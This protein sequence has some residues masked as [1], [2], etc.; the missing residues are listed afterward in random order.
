MN[1]KPHNLS[2]G[3]KSNKQNSRI[4][5]PNSSIFEKESNKEEEEEDEKTQHVHL[6][7]PEIPS[8]HHSKHSSQQLTTERSDLSSGAVMPPFTNMQRK[9]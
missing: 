1:T 6:Q 8:A 9:F 4:N 3:I 7:L 2:L 5:S